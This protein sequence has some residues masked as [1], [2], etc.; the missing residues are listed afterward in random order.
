MTKDSIE[1]IETQAKSEKI[2]Q[3]SY[4]FE[5]D[6]NGN[7]KVEFREVNVFVRQAPLS[8]RFADST[9]LGCFSLGTS[10]FLACLT[11]VDAAGVTQPNLLMGVFIF[12]GGLAQLCAGMWSFAI[13]DLFGATVYS[14]FSAFYIQFAIVYIPGTGII[15]AYTKDGTLTPEF[16]KALSLFLWMYAVLVLFFWLSSF[17]TNLL[18]VTLLFLADICLIMLA[19]GN[20]NGKTKVVLGGAWIGLV[21]GVLI[22]ILGFVAFFEG[23]TGVVIPHG[24]LKHT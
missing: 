21:V 6:I 20:R 7:S 18:L 3:P 12:L 9:P 4:D 14:T 13:K 5:A 15:D 24:S 1:N 2:R 8:E 10:W 11:I 22:W 17:R 16:N 23:M 19:E